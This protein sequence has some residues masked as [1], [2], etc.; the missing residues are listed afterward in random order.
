MT[1]IP[2]PDSQLPVLTFPLSDIVWSRRI[3]SSLPETYTALPA[4]GKV[5][6]EL[7][8]STVNGASIA[9]DIEPV[10]HLGPGLSVV[11]GAVNGKCDKTE[12]KSISFAAYHSAA[13]VQPATA[14]CNSTLLPLLPDHIQSPATVRHLMN[15]VVHITS[16]TNNGQPAVITADQPVYAICKSIQWTYPQLYGED[17]MVLMMGGLHIEMAIQNMI[18]KWLAGSGWTDIFLKAKLL[19]RD[20]VSH[21]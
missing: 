1:V 17:R 9:S 2:H 21:C 18:G 14:A 7:P 13:N 16:S 15:V 12:R 19:Q 6:C 8:L 11:E 4:T 10:E 20:N 5:I 3:S